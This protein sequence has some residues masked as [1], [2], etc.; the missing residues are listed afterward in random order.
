MVFV[1]S[2][3]FLA[4]SFSSGAPSGHSGPEST[5]NNCHGIFGEV[6]TGTG[7][8]SITAP[9]T[10]LAGETVS[11]T[12][13]VDNTTVPDPSPKQGFMLSARNGDGSLNHVGEFD[14]DGS[15]LVRFG[16]GGNPP[17]DSLWVTHTSSSNEMDSWTV[18]WIAPSVSPPATVT[19]YAAGN[20]ANGNGDAD[21]DDFVYTT[22]RDMTLMVVANEPDATPSALSIDALAPNPF[23]TDTDVSYSLDR[24]ATVRIVLRDG[25]GRMV[26]ALENGPK[27][28][29]NHR[30]RIDADGLAPGVY[31]LTVYGP[32]GMKTRPL[33]ISN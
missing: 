16:A 29:G 30:L 28:A 8:V 3:P 15:T 18:S 4:M 7:S 13:E 6:N 17:Q 19:F 32:D 14:L 31:F 22:S 2:I 25:R 23:Q 5:C 24:A 1:V 27:E 26:R 12:V 21:D 10:Y 9:A 20:A 11:I 33:T